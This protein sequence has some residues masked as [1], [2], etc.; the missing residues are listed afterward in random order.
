[1]LFFL[2]GLPAFGSEVRLDLGLGGVDGGVALLLV[3]DLVGGAQVGLGDSA[4]A[5]PFPAP[6]GP[7]R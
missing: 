1:M 6:N 4:S 2:L 7:A 3:G 5:R